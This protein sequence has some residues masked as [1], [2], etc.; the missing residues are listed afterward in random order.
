MRAQPP[1]PDGTVLS[2]KTTIDG[3]YRH[4][5]LPFHGWV[6]EQAFQVAVAAA[7]EW[8]EVRPY[9]APSDAAF[10]E[11]VAAFVKASQNMLRRIDAALA[12]LDLV[13]TRKSV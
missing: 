9:F 13:D 8:E 3:A 5:L 2:L 10:A 7:P 12:R 1:P 4:T 6:T 11:D